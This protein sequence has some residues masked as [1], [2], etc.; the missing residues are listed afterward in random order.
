MSIL[1]KIR[2]MY[3]MLADTDSYKLS[4]YLQYPDGA[5]AMF[6]YIESRGGK[7]DETV[8]FGLQL[9]LKEYF[10]EP[11]TMTHVENMKIFA[12]KHGE[13]FNY[14][15]WKYIV[16]VYGGKIPVLI[17]AVPEGTV[18]PTKNI[19]VSIEST[20][21]DWKTFWLVS[22]FEGVLLR[23]WYTTTVATQSRE[24]KKIIMKYLRKTSDD[25]EGQIMFKLH[26]FGAR[27]VS[28]MES[29]AFGGA[30]HLVNFMGSDTIVGVMAANI[31]YNIEM[32]AFSI[33]A[34]EHSTITSWLR[35]KEFD[36]YRNMIKK[37]GQPGK[38]FAVVSDSF[39]IYDAIEYGW[40]GELKQEVIDSKATLIIRPDSGYPAEVV[41]KCLEILDRKF[42]SVENNKG[43][44]VLNNVRVIQGDGINLDSIEEIL[45]VI[46]QAGFST[47]NVAFGMGGALLQIVNRD[48]QKFAMKCSA[49][50]V[51]GE[52]RDVYKEP[53]TDAGKKSKK[54]RLTLV[55][56]IE[57]GDYYTVNTPIVNE[58]PYIKEVLVDVWKDGELLKEYNFDEVRARA[59]VGV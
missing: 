37:Y 35:A 5:D 51:N 36:A 15:G 52:W 27:G 11:I 19:L 18:V 39:N 53:V 29:A 8:F 40:G 24:A 3:G 57:S 47:D 31:A 1:R 14:D 12:E 34:A 49:M 4:H 22:Y 55:Q 32:S 6:S 21:F 26:D 46:T 17:R 28:S 7:F 45:D 42:G 50:R 10:S 56:N 23:S 43:F 2:E 16:E 38:M 58:H 54:G 48:T 44:K 59:A 25:P 13:P 20:T 41:M 30:A 9:I 33:P